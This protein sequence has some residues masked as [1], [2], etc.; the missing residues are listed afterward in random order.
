M[1]FWLLETSNPYICA[2][3]RSFVFS[4]D[5]VVIKYI[6]REE[7]IEYR[8]N[9]IIPKKYCGTGLSL[10]QWNRPGQNLSLSLLLKNILLNSLVYLQRKI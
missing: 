4:I 1:D 6:I 9:E 8:V 10:I 2:A 3:T 5:K 7:K